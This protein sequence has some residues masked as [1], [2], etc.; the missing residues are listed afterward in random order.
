MREQGTCGFGVGPARTPFFNISD[1]DYVKPMMLPHGGVAHGRGPRL[2]PGL[3][4]ARDKT[5]LRLS[6]HLAPSTCSKL[7]STRSTGITAV[8]ER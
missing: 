7:G 8:G 6:P 5:G 3:L 4:R 1:V 2:A